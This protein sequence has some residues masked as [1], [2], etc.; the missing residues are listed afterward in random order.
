[1]Y[2]S[3]VSIHPDFFR[4][5]QQG[6]FLINGSYSVHQLLWKLFIGEKKRRFLFREEIAREQFGAGTGARGEP[7]YYLVSACRPVA[8]GTIFKVESRDFRPRLKVE[9]RL[10]FDLRA[11]PVVT[12][13]GKKHDIV[14]DAQSNFLRAL[15]GKFDLLQRLPSTPHKKDLK[16]VLL[17]YGGKALGNELTTLLE[18]DFRYA[19]CLQPGMN[20]RDKLEWAN[21]ATIDVFLDNWLL[22]KSDLHGFQLCR[23]RYDQLKLQNS[24]YRWHSLSKKVKGRKKSGFS[25]IDFTG[26]LEVTDVEKFTNTLFTGIGRSKA[27]GCGL[28]LVKRI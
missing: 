5:I 3:R 20:L 14:M 21:K 26:E 16:K 17:A 8:G 1:M 22:K 12:R 19:E 9:T 25:S 15:C 7:I 6:S 13:K 11:N 24:G 2:F 4:T 28:L 27:F 18:N 10:Q 23:N